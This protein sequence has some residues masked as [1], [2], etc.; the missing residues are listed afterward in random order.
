[1]PKLAAFKKYCL[2]LSIFNFNEDIFYKE[3]TDIILPF[4]RNAGYLDI[5]YKI[6]LLLIKH[7]ESKRKYKDANSLYRE[8]L[9]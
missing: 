3:V 4:Y 5:H 8:L 6:T 7:L 1:L 9:S 2:S